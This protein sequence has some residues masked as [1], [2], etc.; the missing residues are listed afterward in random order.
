MSTFTHKMT[1]PKQL[2][3]DRPKNFFQRAMRQ[4]ADRLFADLAR[5]SDIDNLYSQ[6]A[7]YI[8]IQAIVSPPLLRPLGGWALSADAIVYILADLEH[9]ESP[10]LIE[11]GSGEST[12]I[13]ATALHRK[14]AG[15]LLTVEH[16][17]QFMEELS[18]RLSAAQLIQWVELH[19]APLLGHES[20][21][22][23]DY[24]LQLSALPDVQIDLALID[25]PP[26]IRDYGALARLGPLD[27]ALRHLK[28]GGTVFLDD[29]KRPAE[30][31]IV[32]KA[33]EQHAGVISE[34][35]RTE[36]G[37]AMF[38]YRNR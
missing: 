9:R 28:A 30:Q 32:A 31:S 25:G 24:E 13:L 2:P 23:G 19:H 22:P 11:F 3:L 38:R 33:I 34:L 27:W 7:A 36:K 12:I 20:G 37:L 14:N 26:G 4:L 21:N 6:L 8:Q 5:R 10:T 1:S 17:E 16:D 29:A 18:K 15:R 35:I